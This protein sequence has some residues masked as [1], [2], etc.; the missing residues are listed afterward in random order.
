MHR[1]SIGTWAYNIGLRRAPGPVR[2]GRSA[3]NAWDVT[4]RC[5]KSLDELNRKYG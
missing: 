2:R 3:S 5:K 4:E 1:T